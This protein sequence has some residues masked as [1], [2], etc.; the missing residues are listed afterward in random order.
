MRKNI[1]LVALFILVFIGMNGVKAEECVMRAKYVNKKLTRSLS[2]EAPKNTEA[3]RNEQEYYY[4]IKVEEGSQPIITDYYK[5]EIPKS[6]DGY[7]VPGASFQWSYSSDGVITNDGTVKY[8]DFLDKNGNFSCSQASVCQNGN[9]ISSN[10]EGK[11]THKTVDPTYHEPTSSGEKVGNMCDSMPETMALI[12]EIY[13]IMRYAIPVLVIV[14][15]IIDFMKVVINGDE[16]VY[17]EAWNKFI[18]R[19]IVGVIILLVPIL[20]QVLLNI[21]GIVGIY[22]IGSGSDLFCI[23]K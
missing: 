6:A 7:P 16:K 4:K 18:K 23:F 13:N 3:C 19:V 17:A 22:E 21:S 8:E 10:C 1:K 11:E 9:N 20:I 15:S 5:C 12:K 14:L 2:T